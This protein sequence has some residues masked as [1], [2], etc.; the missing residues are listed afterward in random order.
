VIQDA[1]VK[2]GSLYNDGWKAILDY[3]HFFAVDAQKSGVYLVITQ[4]ACLTDEQAQTFLGSLALQTCW[5]V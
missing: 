3:R 5:A 4:K 2:R 1:L